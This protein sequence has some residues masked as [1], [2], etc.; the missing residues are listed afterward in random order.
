M[1][2]E[3]PPYWLVLRGDPNRESEE[4][5]SPQTPYHLSFN[6]LRQLVLDLKL[7]GYSD[8]LITTAVQA[9]LYNHP[10]LWGEVIGALQ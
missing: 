8:S 4:S 1:S 6:T 9:C 10:E 3:E 2:A 5:F 7:G